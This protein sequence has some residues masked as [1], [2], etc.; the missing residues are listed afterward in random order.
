MSKKALQKRMYRVGKK[1]LK[2]ILVSQEDIDGL[3]D[4][5]TLEEKYQRTNRKRKGECK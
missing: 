4:L 5:D 2:R 3:L 1:I